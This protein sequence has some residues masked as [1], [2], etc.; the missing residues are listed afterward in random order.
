MASTR[1]P[2][3]LAARA[4]I[5]LDAASDDP[6]PEDG[7]DAHRVGRRTSAKWLGRFLESGLA[8]LE[9]AARSGRPPVI[10]DEV[11][12]RVLAEPLFVPSAK[13]TSR[14]IARATGVSQSAV[15]R[16]WGRTFD[17][18]LI[19]ETGPLAAL[20]RDSALVGVHVSQKNS[21][22]ALAGVDE[23]DGPGRHGR[24]GTTVAPHAFSM[25]SP[26]RLPVQTILA[27]DLLASRSAPGHLSSFVKSMAAT[28]R[29]RIVLLCREP[30]DAGVLS[31]LDGRPEIQ[32]LAVGAERWQALL[33]HLGRAL[34][35]EGQRT[36]EAVQHSVREWARRPMEPFIWP[37]RHPARPTEVLQRI[38]TPSHRNL[39]PSQ[40]LAE[41]VAASIH[42]A[43]VAGRL[44]GGERVTESS[45]ARATHASR[46][47]IR[48]ALKSLAAD[49]L[50]DLESGRGAVVPRP[51][52]HDV[53]ETYAARRVLG[54]I[55]VGA[56]IR[57]G[58]ESLGPVRSALS[59]MK[60]TGLTG[61]VW[62][63]GEADLRFQDSLAD[64]VEMR[65][66][67]T[68]FRR[69]TMQLRFFI[70]VMGL[71]YAYSVDDMIADDSAL[72]AALTRRDAV[73]AQK[74]WERKMTA[75]V[76]YMVRQLDAG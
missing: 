57:W 72:L 19:S 37:Q 73:S 21:V 41:T 45:L 4:R 71:D 51:S 66:I 40:R 49:G 44:R 23:R 16:L 59:D 26:V 29:G 20:N 56:A 53:L 27:A 63:T 14:T 62:A 74:I 50:V 70:S 76:E 17:P 65:R 18:R 25:R 34:D 46:G 48:D 58:P 64:S 31:W 36:L 30:L 11:V 38:S 9:D 42:D 61:D 6:I 52:V 7:D 47:Q 1:T 13:W 39:S 68:M 10:S 2:S 60:K 28:N 69:L 32:T 75:A 12:L 55:I 24:A 35:P 3:Y 5:V 33:V 8:G 67:P 43:I 15:V 22:I 54:G